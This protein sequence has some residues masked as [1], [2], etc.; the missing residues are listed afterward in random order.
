MPLPDTVR[1]KLSSEAA[2][3]ISITP[4]VVREIPIRE[5][6]EHIVTIAGKDEARVREI[7]LRGTLLSGASRFRWSGWQA[8]P[9]DVRSV[10]AMFP[11]ADPGRRFAAE[12]CTRVV[13]RGGARSIEIPREAGARKALFHHRSY[14]DVLMEE[15]SSADIRYQ[16]YS[17][18]QRADCYRA[19]LSAA[20][21]ERLRAASDDMQY[22]TLREQI[23]S[24]GF[25]WAEVYVERPG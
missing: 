13:L 20:A 8:D 11:D 24:V 22:T 5:L 9:E 14:W 7:L 3:A 2:E 18:R 10:L 6:V 23:R 17:Y 15:L 16:E 19:A 4:V 21:A 12:F 25:L 1:V